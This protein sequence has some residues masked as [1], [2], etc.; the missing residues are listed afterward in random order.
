MKLW[1]SKSSDVPLR[2]Q[3]T[4][5]IMLGIASN[6]LKPDQKLPSTREL[7]RRF[8]IHANTANAAYRELARRGW[9]EF[10]KGSGVYVRA[11]TADAPLDGRLELDQLIAAFLKIA[12]GQGFSLRQIQ[13]RVKHWLELQPPDRF[14]V[15]EPDEGLR[16]L[17]VAE[18]SVATGFPVASAGWEACRDPAALVGSVPVAMYGQAEEVR[19]RLPLD[20]T[21][22][23]LRS[24][25]IDGVV[26]KLQA[27]PSDTSIV[28]VSRWPGFLR[29][30]RAALVAAGID[31][32]A[33][34]A[35]DARA[36]GWQKGL[37]TG[38]FVIADTVTSRQLPAGCP[39]LVFRIIAESSLVELRA[40]VH[41][42]LEKPTPPP[43]D[44]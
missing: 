13:A 5:Q 21:C 24:R 34:S 8:R 44:S 32:L 41:E 39:G 14:L 6:Q 37:R 27:L 2:E 3:L 36:K 22:L 38:V 11:H 12:R 16:R 9:V 40:F 18:I 30:A 15:I 17:L 1:L 28:V 31:P 35:R 33:L 26:R 10:R 23:L 25:P 7:A 42:F 29:W 20:T 43:C 4:T 19:A